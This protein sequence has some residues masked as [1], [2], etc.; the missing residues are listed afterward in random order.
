[1]LDSIHDPTYINKKNL[2]YYFTQCVLCTLDFSFWPGAWFDKGLIL[3]HVFGLVGGL[4][5]RF[6]S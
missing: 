1:M 3:S 2:L 5:L 4:N 6:L